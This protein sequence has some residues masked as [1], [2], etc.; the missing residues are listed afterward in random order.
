MSVVQDPTAATGPPRKQC[1]ACQESIL[2]NATLCTHCKSDQAAWRNELRYWA[3][4]VGVFALIA[5]GVA[6]T[7]SIT[8]AFSEGF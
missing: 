3:G 2:L 1:I 5:S 8:V 4:V 7:T 6:F